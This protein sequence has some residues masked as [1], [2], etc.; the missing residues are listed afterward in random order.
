MTVNV[1]ETCSYYAEILR[2][3]IASAAARM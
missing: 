1:A 2:K 3:E